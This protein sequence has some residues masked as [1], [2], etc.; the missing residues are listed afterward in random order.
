MFCGIST[1]FFRVSSSGGVILLSVSGSA[2]FLPAVH[3][4]RKFGNFIEMN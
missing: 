1:K 4:V 3:T 2:R